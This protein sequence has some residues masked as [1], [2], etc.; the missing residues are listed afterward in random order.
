MRLHANAVAQNC[1]ATERAGRIDGYDADGLPLLAIFARN[2]VHQRA[3]PSARRSGEAEEHS[4]TAVG[5]ERL[6]QLR[7]FGCAVFDGRNGAR[8]RTQFSCTNSADK[9]LGV[10]V[11]GHFGSVLSDQ[12]SPSGFAAR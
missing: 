10:A 6:E 2:L 4:V 3:L 7:G 9:F 5:K 12:P 11:R 8:E 1:T